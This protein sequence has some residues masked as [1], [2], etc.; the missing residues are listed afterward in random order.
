MPCRLI[1]QQRDL[2]LDV[3]G[4]YLLSCGHDHRGHMC[5]GLLLLHDL[6]AIDVHIRPVL[7]SRDHCGHLMRCRLLLLHALSA[8]D[9]HCGPVLPCGDHGGG[10]MPCGLLLPHDLDPHRLHFDALLPSGHDGA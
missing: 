1:L 10:L 9:V 8:L 7:S 5:L 3:F 2:A 4:G 6:P